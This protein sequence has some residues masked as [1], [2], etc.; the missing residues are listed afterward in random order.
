MNESEWTKKICGILKKQTTIKI[1]PLVASVRSQHGLSD[2]LFIHSGWVG[3]VE[4]KGVV[5]KLTNSQV[6][7]GRQCNL[8]RPYSA[9]VWRRV[10]ASDLLVSLEGFDNGPFSTRQHGA[11]GIYMVDNCFSVLQMMIQLSSI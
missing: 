10:L 11:E 1:V 7:F 3:L 5:T 4:F 8:V 9:F 6:M 2:R